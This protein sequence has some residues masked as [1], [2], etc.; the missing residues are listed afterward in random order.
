MTSVSHSPEGAPQR[1]ETRVLKPPFGLELA[2][3]IT[4]FWEGYERPYTPTD[5]NIGFWA[6]AWVED[7]NGL[8]GGEVFI[9]DTTLGVER[10]WD[11]ESPHKDVPERGNYRITTGMKVYL[12][13]GREPQTPEWVIA[14][15]QRE[16]DLL[17]VR[18][19]Q[20]N[21]QFTIEEGILWNSAP[22]DRRASLNWLASELPWK[23]VDLGDLSQ[24]AGMDL[25]GLLTL[26]EAGER[27]LSARLVH[28]ADF[29]VWLHLPDGLVTVTVGEWLELGRDG[30]GRPGQFVLI[31]YGDKRQFERMPH[32]CRACTLFAA[33]DLRDGPWS[34]GV[35]EPFSWM[36]SP[37]SL[38]LRS[39]RRWRSGDPL[40]EFRLYGSPSTGK[41]WEVPREL[42][43]LMLT[44]LTVIEGKSGKSIA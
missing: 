6:R 4:N 29:V 28:V 8:F 14:G 43:R 26:P 17:I 15:P 32:D 19:T 42:S 13:K 33:R 22:L 38:L 1:E 2:S 30:E 44:L 10:I 9:R 11:K 21:E 37:P 31:T 25:Q 20:E 27:L 12:F 18:T 23:L 16:P 34:V 40:P 41:W 7:L 5:D 24:A 3:L 39:G 36:D 35:R